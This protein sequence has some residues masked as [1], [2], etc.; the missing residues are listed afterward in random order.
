M[1]NISKNTPRILI[2]ILLCYVT[3]FIHPVFGQKPQESNPYQRGF[4]PS[5]LNLRSAKY[6][7]DGESG[8]I[9][10][11][12]SKLPG[13]WQGAPATAAQ[14][15]LK[16]YGPNFGVSD[17][18]NMLDLQKVHY[19]PS[20]SHV[21]YSQHLNEIPVYRS[22]LVITLNAAGE[23]IFIA[24]S[25]KMNP[26]PQNFSP[27]LS[28]N[29]ALGLARAHIK[30]QGIYYT[31]PEV[32]LVI[33]VTGENKAQLSY[34]VRIA[35]D[36]PRG[37]WEIL[38]DAID[39]QV[40]KTTNRIMYQ[41][42]VTGRGAVFNPDPLTSAGMYY[43]GGYIDPNGNDQD[44]QFLND[45]RII[46][47]L[48]EIQIQD[49]IYSLS[50]PYVKLVDIE[51]PDDIFPMLTHP[52]SFIYTR[53]EQEFEDVMVYYHIDK[54]YRYLQSLGFDIPELY[55]F[56]VDPHGA[57]GEDNSYYI[58][59]GANFCVFGEG[60]VDDAEDASVIWHEYAHAFQEKIVAP[61]GMIYEGETKSLQEGSSDYWASSYTRSQFEF[62]WQHVFM[63]DAGIVSDDSPGV[64][65]SGRQSD[66][67]M[68]YPD[69]Y[70]YAENQE[71]DNGQIWSSALMHIQGELGKQITD[72]LFIQTHYLWGSRPGFE[73][74]ARAF[75][76]SDSLLY[77]GIHT[78][79]IV[80]WFDHHGLISLDEYLPQISHQPLTD[81]EDIDGPYQ[82]A[83][84]VIPG[85]AE[86]DT[87]NMWLVFWYDDF[88]KDSVHLIV[89]E[90]E[91]LYFAE[92]PG[93]GIEADINYY[94]FVAD[95]L[96][97]ITFDPVIAPIS[98]YSFHVGP[99]TLSPSAEF[100][101]LADQSILRWPAELRV[102]AADNIG[103]SDIRVRYY[104]NTPTALDSFL[105]NPIGSDIY[106]GVFPIVQDSIG[107][108]DSIFYQIE[109]T[110]VS[111]AKHRLILPDSGMYMFKIVSG[112]GT[113]TFNFELDTTGIF[114]SGDWQWGE[115]GNGPQSA[116]EG[117]KLWATGL[118]QLYSDG[119]GLS[120]LILP[121]IDL[122]GFTNATL[123]F[124]HWYD[125]ENKFDGGNIKIKSDQQPDWQLLIPVE[126]YS[127]II[128]T[129]FG[130]PLAGERGY[131]GIKTEWSST[132][133]NLDKFIDEKIQIKFDFG[134]DV[135]ESGLGWYFDL[136]T[137]SDEKAI[138]PA[139]VKLK[140]IDNRD[141]ITL[142]WDSFIPGKTVN[143]LTNAKKE[144]TTEQGES[145]NVLSGSLPAFFIY[146]SLSG[147]DFSLLDS[148]ISASY[149][150]SLVKPG[151][152]YH[153]FVTFSNGESESSPSDTVSA[154]VEPITFLDKENALPRT[155]ALF[156][157][158]PNPFNPVTT[159]NYELPITTYVELSIYNLLG[160]KIETLIKEHQEPGR[161]HVSWNSTG[162]P[163]GV[164][165]YRIKTDHWQ[166]VKKMILI[167]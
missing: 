122:T 113:L 71:H 104:I 134:V 80:R 150:D 92:L 117:D 79:T 58:G 161:Y 9:R 125:I 111:F 60:G 116:F 85:K 18:E 78:S 4:A 44:N 50:G 84:N 36:N 114:S 27:Q 30:V 22:D 13:E 57:F 127:V 110:D 19:S 135:T 158:Y 103:I 106:S 102:S 139:P 28:T 59:G 109:I 86:P 48:P 25:L 144:K 63:W 12:Y 5:E 160:Q 33:L 61:F 17:P 100:S 124:W 146:R 77:G 131:S 167:R 37:D 72:K 105:L 96:N 119:P 138:L 6:N 101:P 87:A 41:D 151:F 136:L 34:C 108:H 3:V 35:T 75:I 40:L 67:D 76:Q 42:Y 53:S 43:G 62:G 82:L 26:R 11:V 54:S 83:V 66:T 159:I 91:Y 164:Y 148:T 130:N 2:L 20:A 128:D 38:V 29:D 142:E 89:D 126:G 24:N 45:Q 74:A 68:R 115:P 69:D 141:K 8:L 39:G 98:F 65:W 90:T 94:I 107:I 143:R 16:S 55:R 118:N 154:I 120:E 112:G 32:Q 137:I 14:N 162:Y 147:T 129:S 157:N 149:S 46:V 93:P 52:D 49:S 1:S 133:F 156:Q 132:K 47:D 140:V 88:A 152:N 73:D 51:S 121:E 99:D 31:D 123:Q 165:L 81:T 97:S 70:D 21:I 166:D 7:I 155:Y 10:Y 145:G 163:T 15:F 23:V 56:N 153:Y 95:S 64:F